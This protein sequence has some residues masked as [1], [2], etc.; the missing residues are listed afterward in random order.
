M[1][2]NSDAKELLKKLFSDTKNIIIYCLLSA[3]F[4]IIFIHSGKPIFKTSLIILS[5]FVAYFSSM[6]IVGRKITQILFWINFYLFT[7]IIILSQ[8]PNISLD[9]I[10]KY[11]PFGG[12]FVTLFR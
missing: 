1:V 4:A 3:C 9:V 8:I 2:D 6:F 5:S 10:S 12:L 11:N 7:G